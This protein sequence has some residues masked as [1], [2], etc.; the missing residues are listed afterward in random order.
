MPKNSEAVYR[1]SPRKTCQWR[2]RGHRG[3]HGLK[4][5]DVHGFRPFGSGSVPKKEDLI[6]SI[7]ATWWFQLFLFNLYP[8]TGGR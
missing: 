2:I 3:L 1:S 5:A 7:M 4:N 6:Q 8:E